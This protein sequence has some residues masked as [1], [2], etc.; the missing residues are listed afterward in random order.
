MTLV[1]YLAEE[2]LVRLPDWFIGGLAGWLI[3]RGGKGRGA[4]VLVAVFYSMSIVGSFLGDGMPD[5]TGHALA[6]I[7]FALM[8][9]LGLRQ[10]RIASAKAPPPTLSRG[11]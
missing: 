1:A 10:P 5:Y 9:W 7:A 6:V 3:G 4:G 2:F 11:E 8:L